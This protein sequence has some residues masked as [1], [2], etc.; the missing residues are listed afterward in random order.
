MEELM[1]TIVAPHIG[2]LYSSVIADA[3]HRWQR[4]LNPAD[5]T[6]FATGTD[7]HGSKI[8][9]AAVKVNKSLPEYCR[10]ISGKYRDLSAKFD[11]GYSDFIRTTDAEHV[12]AVH[13]FWVAIL[14]HLIILGDDHGAC[15]YVAAT[16]VQRH[17][18]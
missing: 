13:E 4:L 9:Q 7:E 14:L 10:E 12:A 2:H 3:I 11:V 16:H 5:E 15:H 6:C 8:Q 18:H 17:A 1:F